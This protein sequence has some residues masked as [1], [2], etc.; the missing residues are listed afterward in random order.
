MTTGYDAVKH[1]IMSFLQDR[2]NVDVLSPEHDL[3][4]AGILDSLMIVELVLY[5]EQTF[6]VAL[7]LEDLEIENFAT[8]VGMAAFV[9]ARVAQSSAVNLEERRHRS[10]A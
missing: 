3:V 4:E 8:V 5:F 10:V 1:S 9:T 7:S 2:L 6:A